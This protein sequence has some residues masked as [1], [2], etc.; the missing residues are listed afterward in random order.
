MLVDVLAF[1]LFQLAFGLVAF[2]LVTPSKDLSGGF[3][4]L[5]GV[6]ALPAAVLAALASGRY[7]LLLREGAGPSPVL[8]M[9]VFCV[10]LGVHTL[11]AR[12]RRLGLARLALTPA[13]LAGGWL[14]V[15]RAGVAPLAGRGLGPG[16]TAAGLLLGG[17]LFGGVVWA[18]NVGHWYLV[19][20]T[21]PFQLLVGASSAFG[22]LVVARAVLAGVALWGLAPHFAAPEIASL[23]D[24]FRDA[25]FFWSR[26][27][28][29]IVAPIVLTPFVVRT[30]RMRS[31]QA[32]TGLLY[33]GLVFVMVGELL[34]TYLTLRSGLPA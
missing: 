7:G 19:S 32:A 14:L 8:L 5:H 28:W 33:V 23:V 4:A 24:P 30:A 18:M 3:F 2:N 26:V 31:N 12:A 27:L 13:L 1:T 34:A 11:V 17:L 16:W 20:K 21:L 29:G 15:S 10:S 9:V 25:F 22:A 6:L